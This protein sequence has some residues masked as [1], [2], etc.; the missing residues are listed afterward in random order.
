APVASC[1]ANISVGNDLG[2]CTAVVSF[3]VSATDNCPGVS[4]VASPASGSTFPVGTTPVTVIVTD[5]SGK[6]DTCTFNVTVSDN[7]YPTANCPAN[8]T[9]GNDLGLCTAVVSFSA[10]GADNCPG[11][12]VVASPA[13]GSAFPVGT[14]PVTVIVTDASGKADTCTFNVTVNDNEDPI[15]NCPANITVGNDLGL[16]TAVVSFSVSATDNCPGVS[17]VASPASGSTFPVGTTPVT[18]IATDASGNADTCTFN[19]TVNETES[20]SIACPADLAV[21]CSSDV[22]APNS[23]LVVASDNCDVAPTVTFQGDVSD[24]LS[25]PETI[26]RTY[27]ATDNSDNWAE[28]TQ[29]IVINDTFAPTFDQ[30]TIHVR[31]ASKAVGIVAS[32]L[33]PKKREKCDSDNREVQQKLRDLHQ[34]RQE[35]PL[36]SYRAALENRPTVKFGNGEVARPEFLGRR[37]LTDFDLE[38]IVPYIDW[39]FFFSAWELKGRYPKILEHPEMGEAARDLFANGQSLLARIVEQ[40]QLTAQAVYGFWPANSVGDDIVLY[41]DDSRSDELLR[42]PMLRQQEELA[43]GMFN[44]S[45]ADYIAPKESGVEDY[46]G[47]FAVTTGLGATKLTDDFKSEHDDYNAIMVQSLADR[48]AEAFAEYLHAR[49]RKEWGIAPAAGESMDD[50]IEERYRGIRPAFGYPACPDHSLKN[51]LFELLSAEEVGMELTESCAVSP[52]ASVSGLYFGNPAAKYFTV[53]RLDRDQVKNYSSRQKTNLR[54]V[55]KWLAPYLTYDSE[56]SA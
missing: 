12:S 5:A 56:E 48:L 42:F 27:R 13:S 43:K 21:Q 32:L 37:V 24:G 23:G 52:A 9:V 40:K 14:T 53:G 6:A 19:V 30:P 54:E 36:R 16:C 11:F 39:T 38:E 26:T 49:A 8:I 51:S 55:E 47:A 45:L 25:C 28:C 22:P 2:L 41:R 7:E 17:V 1:P 33:D 15:A 29:L 20:P 34:A 46:I 18:V 3:S 10:T 50:L 35:K 44:R 4:V 31:D